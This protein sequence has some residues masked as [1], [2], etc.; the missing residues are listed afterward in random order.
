LLI[1]SIFLLSAVAICLFWGVISSIPSRTQELFGPPNP[2]LTIWKEFSQSLILLRSQDQLLN[3]IDHDSPDLVV[4]IKAGDTPDQVLNTLINLRLVEH[5]AAFRAYLI[6]S[7]IDTKLQPGDYQ[8]PPDISELELA[9]LLG[10]PGSKL[11]N[12]SILA[13]WRSEE[14]GEQLTGLGFNITQQQFAEAV[15]RSGREGF[16]FPTTYQVMREISADELVERMYQEFFSQITPELESGFSAKGLTMDQAVIL[17]SIIQR[18]AVVEEEMP[19]IASV[20]LNR[21]DQGLKLEAD[22]TVQYA[23]GYNA[24]QET[25]WTN[26]LSLEDLRINSP[27]NTYEYPGLPPGPICNPGLPALR[28]VANPANTNYQYFRSACDGS[29]RHLFA[30]TFEDHLDNAC[31]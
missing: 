13:G 24:N 5:G 1:I 11:V 30:E 20:F 18:E 7:G 27:Y 22:P 19:L 28:A 23:L 9:N 10:Q 12:L 4:S 2:E 15:M 17:A 14:I 25:W 8:F 31:P 16:L 26:P 21:L 29:G 6:Y 3:P